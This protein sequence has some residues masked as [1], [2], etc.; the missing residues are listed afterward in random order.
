MEFRPNDFILHIECVKN[1]RCSS[2]KMRV[3]CPI[4]HSFYKGKL[5]TE[6]SIQEAELIL[7]EIVGEDIAY[8]ATNDFRNKILC[9]RGEHPGGYSYT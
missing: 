4:R 5:K 9:E 2:C 7:R 8:L 6:L 1:P 3:G